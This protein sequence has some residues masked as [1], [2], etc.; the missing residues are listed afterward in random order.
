[1]SVCI[2]GANI[3]NNSCILFAKISSWNK[4][5]GDKSNQYLWSGLWLMFLN[6]LS[7]AIGACNFCFFLCWIDKCS[8]QKICTLQ[9]YCSDS[10]EKKYLFFFPF[11]HL[12]VSFF[13][14]CSLHHTIV[15]T[16][17][18]YVP[19]DLVHVLKQSWTLTFTTMQ[20]KSTLIKLYRNRRKIVSCLKVQWDMFIVSSPGMDS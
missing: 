14:W 2:V 10:K 1:M 17:C 18:K 13:H 4:G 6:C 3:Y 20:Q 7:C 8:N 19:F 11:V 15:T 16:E 9:I 5:W 12:F